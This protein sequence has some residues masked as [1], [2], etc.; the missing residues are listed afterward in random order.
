MKADSEL[1]LKGLLK[2][3]I[4]SDENTYIHKNT[5]LKQASEQHQKIYNYVR[6]D[7]LDKLIENLDNRFSE[8]DMHVFL[9]VAIC[10][11]KMYLPRMA[12]ITNFFRTESEMLISIYESVIDAERDQKYLNIKHT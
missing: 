10:N 7:H 11:T 4:S 3:I 12:Q 1:H 9:F 5:A 2:E 6:N 8:N